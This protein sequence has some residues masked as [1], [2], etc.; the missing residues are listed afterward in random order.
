MVKELI[1]KHHIAEYGMTLDQLKKETE[2]HPNFKKYPQMILVSLLLNIQ[3]RVHNDPD[4]RRDLN[5]AIWFT[6]TYLTGKSPSPD[7]TK[8][9]SEYVSED[10]DRGM[11]IT[12][13]I[14]TEAFHSYHNGT[15]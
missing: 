9:I 2:S 14:I 7:L 6:Q 11:K 10:L 4:L 1:N 13:E 15:R 3:S 8:H 5:R 12:P